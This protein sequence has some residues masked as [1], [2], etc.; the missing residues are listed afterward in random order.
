MQLWTGRSACFADQ[1]CHCALQPKREAD[2]ECSCSQLRRLGPHNLTHQSLVLGTNPPRGRAGVPL[3]ALPLS[4]ASAFCL[5]KDNLL[6]MMQ[7]SG[8]FAL[9]AREPLQFSWCITTGSKY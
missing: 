4:D 7:T 5:Q 3:L 1:C 9:A 2:K 6:L 8:A